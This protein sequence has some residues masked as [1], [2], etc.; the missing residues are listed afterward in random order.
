LNSS[1]SGSCGCTSHGL[2]PPP[3]EAARS[4]SFKMLELSDRLHE[5]LAEASDLETLAREE[6]IP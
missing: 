3:I 4:A 5:S 6:G 1:R 2:I